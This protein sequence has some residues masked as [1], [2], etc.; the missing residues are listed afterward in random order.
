MAFWIFA[1]FGF[2]VSGTIR[3]QS[4]KTA[5]SNQIQGWT[6]YV[7]GAFDRISG[8]FLFSLLGLGSVILLALAA[9]AQFSSSAQSIVAAASPQ[10]PGAH[11]PFVGCRAD[12]QGGPVDAP[13]GKSRVLPIAAEAAHRLAYYRAEQGFGV[14]APR[15]WYC[16]GVYGS[17]GYALYLSS[18]QI[19]TDNLFSTTWSGFAGPVI[20]I[21]GE[22]GETSGR[23]GVAR[24][25]ARV[26]PAHKAFVEKVIEEGTEPAS[27]FPFGPYPKD[28]LT[29]RSKE[30]VEYQTPANTDGLGTNSRLKKDASP[31]RGVAILMGETPDLLL[32]SVRLSPN[33]ADL[34]PAIVKQVERDAV[35]A[36]DNR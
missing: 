6:C 2:G 28:K 27:S 4:M 7:A 15:G 5:P 16:F 21:A 18:Q 35:H 34:T 9:C 29:Y 30:I 1:C 12:G 17:N 3:Q 26:F 19:S 33:L 14:L 13:N 23:F 32:L 24:T 20:E 22:S 36:V 25:I 8:S 10:K 11:V 31:I